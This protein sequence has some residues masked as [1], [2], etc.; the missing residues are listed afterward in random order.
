MVPVY[1]ITVCPV[2][3]V[4]TLVPVLLRV[5]EFA[6]EPT[7]KNVYLYRPA[8]GAVNI[9]VEAKPPV[10]KSFS[11]ST[12]VAAAIGFAAVRDV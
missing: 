10:P 12:I 1:E 2:P 9:P 7:R 4:I 6:A 11:D 3:I 8:T 5:T